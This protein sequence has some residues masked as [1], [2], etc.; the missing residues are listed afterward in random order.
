MDLV[1]HLKQLTM[2]TGLS[3]FETEVRGLVQDAWEPLA[4]EFRTD[5]LGNLI[6]LKRGVR[7]AGAPGAPSCWRRTWTR[8]A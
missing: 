4:D 6:A 1:A 2:A 5:A 8:S 7:P 3:G